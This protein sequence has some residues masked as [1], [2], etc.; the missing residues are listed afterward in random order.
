LPVSPSSNDVLCIEMEQ[1]LALI[2]R[3]WTSKIVPGYSNCVG[4]LSAITRRLFP[5]T[6][7][8]RHYVRILAA[9]TSITGRKGPCP[10]PRS[11]VKDTRSTLS[12]LPIRLVRYIPS[13]GIISLKVSGD[14]PS[15]DIV[16]IIIINHRL[17][18]RCDR[19]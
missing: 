15:T 18:H 8:P 13:T 19:L 9:K 17:R 16:D 2:T 1:M 14:Q 5:S 10:H 12:L 11:V 4:T 6:P 7:P 3:I